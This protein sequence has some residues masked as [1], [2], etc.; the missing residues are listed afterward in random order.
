[1]QIQHTELSARMK[2]IPFTMWMDFAKQIAIMGGG[3]SIDIQQYSQFHLYIEWC[4]NILHTHFSDSVEHW[5]A[6]FE[7]NQI[8]TTFNLLRELESIN[9]I[10]TQQGCNYS[11]TVLMDE[12]YGP[13]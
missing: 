3:Y 10:D 1:M 13:H 8:M 6:A 7:D 11:A 4:A 9:A 12:C 5:G 2:S